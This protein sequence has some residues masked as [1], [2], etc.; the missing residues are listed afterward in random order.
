MSKQGMMQGVDHSLALFTRG[1]NISA[2]IAE[3]LR[4]VLCAER[5][6]NLLL[7]LHHAHVTLCQIIIKRHAKIRDESKCFPLIFLQAIQ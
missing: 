3:H 7:N 6:R 1:R 2:Q 5:P 4:A